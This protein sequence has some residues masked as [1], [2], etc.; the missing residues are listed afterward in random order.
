MADEFEAQA[1][2]IQDRLATMTDE[3][4]R[5]A[6]LACEGE[7]GEPLLEALVAELEAR[8]IDI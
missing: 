2:D 4:L 8:N 7:C 5:A 1:L 3:E 6:Y